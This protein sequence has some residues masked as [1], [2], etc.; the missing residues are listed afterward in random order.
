MSEWQVVVGATI[1]GIILR[2]RLGSRWH[3]RLSRLLWE[4]SLSSRLLW[5]WCLSHRLLWSKR[6]TTS[7]LLHTIGSSICRLVYY[8]PHII[9][10]DTVEPSSL[11]FTGINIE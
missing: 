5:E 11:I 4:R 6:S 3:L 9:S 1:E 8:R 2:C 10:P 7:R